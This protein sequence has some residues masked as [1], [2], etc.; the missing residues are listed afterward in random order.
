MTAVEMMLAGT[1]SAWPG[2]GLPTAE[3]K[4]GNIFNDSEYPGSN[5]AWLAPDSKVRS[6]KWIG[7]MFRN[8][9]P[10]DFFHKDTTSVLHK[11]SPRFFVLSK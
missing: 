1:H 9:A 4:T 7:F 10:M 8:K 2:N 3:D 11:S 5:T 6:M